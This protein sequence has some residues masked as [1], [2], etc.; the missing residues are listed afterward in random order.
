[1]VTAT[2]PPTPHLHLH[3]PRPRHISLQQHQGVT[4]RGGALPLG[5]GNGCG[6]VVW[7]SG[8]LHALAA[9]PADCLDQQ[10]EAQRLRLPGEH[11]RGLLLAVVAC[12]QAGCRCGVCEG[13]GGVGWVMVGWGGVGWGGVGWGS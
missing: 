4:K 5:R 2:T 10:G 8:Q 3:M 13:D 1:M 12:G 11:L 6:Q 9:P 7:P